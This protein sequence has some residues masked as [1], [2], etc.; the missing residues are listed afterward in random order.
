MAEEGG[1]DDGNNDNNGN[2]NNS[3]DGGNN[4]IFILGPSEGNGPDYQPGSDDGSI[5]VNGDDVPL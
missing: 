5:S 3:N 1:S 2:N 4:G